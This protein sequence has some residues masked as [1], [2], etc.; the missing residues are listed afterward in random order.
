[1][2]STNNK[3][4]RKHIIFLDFYFIL[5][6]RSYSINKSSAQWDMQYI[7]KMKRKLLS[8]EER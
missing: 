8:S 4:H 7:Q 1:V 3:A 5:R 2:S 6:L